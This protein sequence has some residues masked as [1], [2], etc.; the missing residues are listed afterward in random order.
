MIPRERPPTNLLNV[1]ARA[2]A[3]FYRRRFYRFFLFSLFSNP[4]QRLISTDTKKRFITT[5][6]GA[7]ARLVF[8]LIGAK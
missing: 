7:E 6:L 1:R 8:H 2:R 4:A 3:L 5:Q